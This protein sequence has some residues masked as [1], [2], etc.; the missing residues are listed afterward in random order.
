[1][2][3]NVKH[4]FA[5]RSWRGDS[6]RAAHGWIHEHDDIL[7]IENHHAVVDIIKDRFQ[8]RPLRFGD[9]GTF[10]KGGSSAIDFLPEPI[11]N[12]M[13]IPETVFNDINDI[14]C[15]ERRS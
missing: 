5:N 6:K 1:M 11:T 3:N 10:L 9:L 12:T 13:G 7:W 15:A 4:R 2:R 8:P 14:I